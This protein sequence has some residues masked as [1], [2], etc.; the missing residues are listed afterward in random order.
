MRCEAQEKPG[1]LGKSASYARLRGNDHVGEGTRMLVRIYGAIVAQLLVAPDSSVYRS[2]PTSFPMPVQICG[3]NLH[4]Q[5][6]L[7]GTQSSSF[8]HA[9]AKMK[10]VLEED[11]D[12]WPIQQ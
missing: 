5:P 1:K 2:H 3:Y 11:Y 8:F 12:I 6:C 4:C 9:H 7:C 10:S